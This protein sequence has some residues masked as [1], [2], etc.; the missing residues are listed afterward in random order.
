[1]SDFSNVALVVELDARN[2]L[3][4]CSLLS[5]PTLGTAHL[6]RS[7]LVRHYHGGTR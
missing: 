2:L 3:G 6:R 4:N 1:M 5:T 7:V